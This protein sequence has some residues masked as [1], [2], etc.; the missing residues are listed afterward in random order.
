[1][2][3]DF[4]TLKTGVINGAILRRVKEMRAQQ[5]TY[6]RSHV[7]PVILWA[8]RF[9]SWKHPEDAIHVA[10]YL[11]HFGYDYELRLIG[12]GN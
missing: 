3:I 5:D 12:G 4:Q 8:G 2:L 11:Q 1:M 10:R 9:I 6:H 7:K